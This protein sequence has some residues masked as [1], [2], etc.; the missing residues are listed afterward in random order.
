ME[1][2]LV[3]LPSCNNPK[4]SF[5]A[6]QATSSMATRTRWAIVVPVSIVLGIALNFLGVPAAWVLAALICSASAAIITHQAL[7]L[8]PLMVRFTKGVIGIIA[9]APLAT[10]AW[11]DLA[12][13][14]IPGLV[15][16]AIT[17]ATGISCG[18]IMHRLHKDIDRGSAVLSMLA[19]GASVMP[20]LAAEMK[21]DIRYV[22][23]TQYLR[24]MVVTMTLPLAATLI[25][26]HDPAGTDTSSASTSVLS[27]K[28]GVDFLTQHLSFAGI[29]VLIMVIILGEPVGKILHIPS[30]SLLGPLFLSVITRRILEPATSID[31]ALPPIVTITGFIAVGFLAG[32]GLSAP[33]LR[34]CA[35]ILPLTLFFIALLMG[36]CALSALA[37]VVLS[38]VPYLD[39]YLASTPGGLEAVLAV[40][41]QAHSGPLVIAVQIIRLLT[42]LIVAGYL[43]RFFPSA[44]ADSP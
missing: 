22:T 26:F 32:G 4:R 18:L 37:L 43:P 13:Y 31:L 16:S 6:L 21:A 38:D 9:A 29:A 8:S 10:T 27:H 24:V 28:L 1:V 2:C 35:R 11:R 20:F 3:R 15:V 34:R 30:P 42:V 36:V 44:T 23:L 12:E 17:I 5:L 41:D 14:I 39:A 33:A 7:S 40:A 19:G 25:G